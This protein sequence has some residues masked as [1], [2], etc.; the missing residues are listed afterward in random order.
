MGWRK[1]TFLSIQAHL[2]HEVSELKVFDLYNNQFDDFKSDNDGNYEYAFD[3]PNA[4]LEF[5]GD[6]KWVRQGTMQRYNEQY[7]LRLHIGTTSYQDSHSGSDSQS[8]ALDHLDFVDK[9]INALD[10]FS[11]QPHLVK[12]RF[13]A[14]RIDHDRSNMIHHQ[15]NCIAHVADNSLCEANPPTEQKAMTKQVNAFRIQ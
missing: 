8:P 1:Q 12:L 14:E 13:V 6:G 2:L 9:I 7:L 11:A 10:E 15:I 4:F 3:F 5:V